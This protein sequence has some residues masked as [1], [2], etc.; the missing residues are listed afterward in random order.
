MGDACL[1][2]AGIVCRSCEDAC[3]ELAIRFRPR[4][5]LPPQ[6][7]VNEAVCTGCGE[8]ASVCPG[9]AIILG[10]AHRRSAS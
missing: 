3:P 10:S 2:E 1:A 5:D 4:T 8:C 6:A 7:I 9:D